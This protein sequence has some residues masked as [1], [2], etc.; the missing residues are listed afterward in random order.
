LFPPTSALHLPDARL[1]NN[2]IS[3]YI[4][5]YIHIGSL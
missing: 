3:G 2:L 4:T 5:G 1:A